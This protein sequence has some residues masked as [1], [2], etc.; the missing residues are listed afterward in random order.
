MCW[1]VTQIAWSL[2]CGQ[3]LLRD[4]SYD[5]QSNWFWALQTLT[6]GLDF[7]AK[8]HVKPDVFV[9]QVQ[10]RTDLHVAALW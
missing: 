5:G 3:N 10:I 6:H 1:S 9:V 7:L 4:G 8:C 2:I